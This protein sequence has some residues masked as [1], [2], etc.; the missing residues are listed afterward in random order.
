MVAHTAQFQLDRPLGRGRRIRRI[1]TVDF[2]FTMVVLK[3]GSVQRHT[4]KVYREYGRIP[5]DVADETILATLAEVRRLFEGLPEITKQQE[6]YWNA[7]NREVLDRL[8]S[9]AHLASKLAKDV[10]KNF[11]SLDKLQA[12]VTVRHMLRKLRRAGIPVIG[13]TNATR[14]EAYEKLDHFDLLKELDR[15]WTSEELGARKPDVRHWERILELEKLPRSTEVIHI[16]NSLFS[17]GGATELPKS[18]VHI[19]D[20]GGRYAP[21]SKDVV[22]DSQFTAERAAAV[23]RYIRTGRIRFANSRKQLADHVLGNP[24][25][26]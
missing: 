10:R 12:S 21:H 4:V 17:D 16:G 2:G 5:D 9:Q 24:I 25:T 3:A 6:V 13:A 26:V 18:K 7:V 19:I 22:L 15:L 8:S 20:K 1:A 14:E 23:R 11:L